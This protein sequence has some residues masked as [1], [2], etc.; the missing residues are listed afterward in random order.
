MSITKEENSSLLIAESAQLKIPD[1][2]LNITT[3]LNKRMSIRKGSIGKQTTNQIKQKTPEIEPMLK[4]SRNYR[5]SRI[6]RVKT[7]NI[8]IHFFI[9]K[10]SNLKLDKK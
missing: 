7:K 5:I 3:N 6:L 9:N 10:H 4:N 2:D 8:D 1:E